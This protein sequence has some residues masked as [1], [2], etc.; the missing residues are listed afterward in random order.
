MFLPGRR[1]WLVPASRAED[2]SE[3]ITDI[4]HEMEAIGYLLGRRRG[5]STGGRIGFS[6]VPCQNSNIRMRLEPCDQ[7]VSRA[8]LE[9]RDGPPTFQIDHQRAIGTAFAPGKLID[10]QD[11]RRGSHD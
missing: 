4:T 8:A 7:G 3:G 6:T 1:H 11:T 5:K 2:D 10:A 9:H